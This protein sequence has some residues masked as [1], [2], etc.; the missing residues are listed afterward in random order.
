MKKHLLPLVVFSIAICSFGQS[1]NDNKELN[2]FDS[3]ISVYPNPA[4][5]FI[6]INNII[7]MGVKEIEV[8]NVIGEKVKITFASGLRNSVTLDIGKLSAG[9]FFVRFYDHAGKIVDT[10]K[11]S[12]EL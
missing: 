4:K 3:K 9:I 2:N 5:D 1:L 6:I 11:I 10:K 7:D 12:K 8:F